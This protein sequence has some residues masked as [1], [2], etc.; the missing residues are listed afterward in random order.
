M[1]NGQVPLALTHAWSDGTTHLLFDPV[2]LLARLAVLTPRPRINLINCGPP[3][4]L[5]ILEG[6]PAPLSTHHQRRGITRKPVVRAQ[7]SGGRDWQH[8]YLGEE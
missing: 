7:S 3:T 4:P 1:A 6:I 5:L 2:E 8:H